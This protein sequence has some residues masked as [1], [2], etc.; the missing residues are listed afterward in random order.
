MWCCYVNVAVALKLLLLLLRLLLALE[1]SMDV[2]CVPP[3]SHYTETLAR[4]RYDSGIRPPPTTTRHTVTRACSE[5][6][7]LCFID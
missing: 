6:G 1:L 5:T 3:T 2:G 4:G 7:I